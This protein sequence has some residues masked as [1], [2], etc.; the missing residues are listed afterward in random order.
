MRKRHRR[1]LRRVV[2][3]LVSGGAGFW[4]GY[5]VFA[6]CDKA[7]GL[8]L[9]WS[10]LAAYLTVVILNFFLERYWVFWQ[11]NPNRQITRVSI[12]YVILLG[13]NFGIDYSIV[14]GLKALG[15]T[16]YLGQF[17]SAGFFT[18]WNYLWYRNW[19]FRRGVA[20]YSVAAS[21]AVTHE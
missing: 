15:V 14:R 5:G 12:R 6:L 10:K 19:V 13:L 9:F 17:V 1:E 7:L 20:R 4:T 8:S 2:A 3:Y 11:R 21:A 18:L 16:P